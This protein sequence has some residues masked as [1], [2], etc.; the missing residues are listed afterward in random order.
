MRSIHGLQIHLR[1][2]I[3][4]IEYHSVSCRQIDPQPSG[5]C[6]E[7]KQEMLVCVHKGFYLVLPTL[8]VSISVDSAISVPSQMTEIFKDVQE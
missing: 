7:E 4:I 3:A 5:S 1:I 2:E 6:A 8:H